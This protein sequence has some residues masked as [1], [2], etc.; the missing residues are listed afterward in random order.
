M[1]GWPLTVSS[2]RHWPSPGSGVP[3]RG[4][5]PPRD[6]RLE[7]L[8]ALVP[9]RGGLGH[10]EG[11]VRLAAHLGRLV[12]QPLA[13]R[14]HRAQVVVPGPL[15]QLGGQ[16][17]AVGRG[18][19][20]A[21]GEREP[22]AEHR[23]QGQDDLYRAAPEQPA[24]P[25]AAL[26]P[27]A[28]GRRLGP[29]SARRRPGRWRPGPRSASPGGRSPAGSY[30]EGC[31]P[32]GGAFSWLARRDAGRSTRLP[33]RRAGEVLADGLPAQH[34][35]FVTGTG[36]PANDEIPPAGPVRP[37]PGWPVPTSRGPA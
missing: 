6:D 26:D 14:H 25:A 35:G 3:G 20:L 2:T 12:A 21:D 36:S 17:A 19:R 22:A 23:D 32:G 5:Q 9:G 8:S 4:G 37:A 10:R 34:E 31:G 33:P 27:A 24:D 16:R 15:G 30:G 7:G 13:E 29:A 28:S 11:E 18:Q 1:A